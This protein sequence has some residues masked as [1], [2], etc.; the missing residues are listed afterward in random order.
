MNNFIGQDGS[1]NLFFLKSLNLI[2]LK[3][4]SIGIARNVIGALYLVETI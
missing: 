1:R 3:T 4:P 2:A